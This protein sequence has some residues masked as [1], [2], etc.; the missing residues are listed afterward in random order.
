VRTAG[1]HVIEQHNWPI[2]V[3]ND[4]IDIFK[5]IRI[6]WAAFAGFAP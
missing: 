5:I 4:A 2:N 3:G 6:A 1:A